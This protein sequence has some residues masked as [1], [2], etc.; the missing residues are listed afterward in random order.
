MTRKVIIPQ[1]DSP[2]VDEKGRLNLYGHS[3]ARETTNRV[4]ASSQ[5]ANAE[6]EVFEMSDFGVAL[7]RVIT[8]LPVLYTMKAPIQTANRFQI[9]ENGL[10]QIQSVNQNTNFLAYVGGDVFFSSPQGVVSL[11]LLRTTIA[12]VVPGATLFDIVGTNTSR[13]PFGVVSSQIENLGFD[14]FFSLGSI[15]NTSIFFFD[16]IIQNFTLGLVL[17]NCVEVVI[18]TV[19]MVSDFQAAGPILTIKG[20][21]DRS[22]ISSLTFIAGP[23]Q[24]GFRIDPGI[25]NTSRLQIINAAVRG[26]GTLFDTSGL[27]GRV[28]GIFTAVEDATVDA[29]LISKVEQGTPIPGGFAVRFIQSDAALFA[30]QIV[31]VSGYLV[32]SAYN[33]TARISNTGPGFFE[34]Y[35]VLFGSEESGGSFDSNSVTLTLGNHPLQDGDTLTIDTDSSIDYDG[36]SYV[37]NTTQNTFQI[38]ASFTEDMNGTWST[39]G[40]DQKDPRVLLSASPDFGNS[41]Y[42]GCGFVNNNEVSNSVSN[43]NFDPISFG[44]MIESTLS[45]RWKLINA[46]FGYFQYFGNEPF[47]GELTF[48][49][50][51]KTG[52]SSEQEYLFQVEISADGVIWSA[53]ADGVMMKIGVKNTIQFGSKTF[54]VAA[55]KGDRIRITTKGDGTNVAFIISYSSIYIRG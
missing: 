13:S 43:L 42:I 52:S 49:F 22:N 18:Q 8:P 50:S 6:V 38:N 5:L 26:P 51:V 19:L 39:A 36:G 47:D 15:E 25:P 37:Y 40:L 53:L 21:T 10:F 7:N 11:L 9:P 16:S 35:D 27:S 29:T 30:D 24:Q 23:T 28:S 20:D 1:R 4:N 41:A 34:L 54:P 33:T 2:L 14:G 55:V 45:E 12:S 44:T 31:T 17:E 46:N 3:W 32:N 48:D